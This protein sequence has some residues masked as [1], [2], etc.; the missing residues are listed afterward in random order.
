MCHPTTTQKKRDQ[1]QVSALSQEPTTPI[2]IL[3]SPPILK[4]LLEKKIKE[5]MAGKAE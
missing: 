4:L 3:E 1:S 2:C 5:K